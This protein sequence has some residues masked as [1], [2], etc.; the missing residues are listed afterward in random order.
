MKK[1]LKGFL[2]EGIISHKDQGPKPF[3][4][5][6][7]LYNEPNDKRIQEYITCMK[8]NLAHPLIDEIYVLYD[9]SKD[10]DKNHI[11][12]FLEDNNVN[13]SYITSRPTYRYCFE[14]AS[15]TFPNSRVILSNADIFFNETLTLLDN[16]DLNNTILTLSR[17]KLLKNEDGEMVKQL[18]IFE[19]ITQCKICGHQRRL[20]R[21][22]DIEHCEYSPPC[23]EA[24]KCKAKLKDLKILP[25]KTA[26][27]KGYSQ[28]TWIFQTPF[29][30]TFRCD[31]ELGMFH[32]DSFLNYH[33]LNSGFKVYN[34]CKDI[35]CCHLHQSEV[36]S[37]DYLQCIRNDDKR[38]AEEKKKGNLQAGIPWSTLSC[39]SLSLMRIRM[40]LEVLI[41]KLK[42][43]MSMI[44]FLKEAVAAIEK[45][46]KSF[47]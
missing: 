7:S 1:R 17:W 23:W 41:I 14:Y 24:Y 32:C 12:K 38:L 8:R 42:F 34:P 43:R 15:K 16:F 6:T 35:Q 28:D 47:L 44:P 30:I 31:F 13:I 22:E 18:K 2:K 9:S 33:L 3:K 27:Y 39:C 4:L 20:H 36:R 19:V 46:L 25:G 11:L 29:A 21:K 26:D 40:K 5:I 45:G 37:E 10:N